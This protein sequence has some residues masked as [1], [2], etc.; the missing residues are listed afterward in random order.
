MPGEAFT[1]D[2]AALAAMLDGRLADRAGLAAVAPHVAAASQA[3]PFFVDALLESG[4]VRAVEEGVRVRVYALD[5]EELE[6]VLVALSPAGAPQLLLSEIPERAADFAELDYGDEAEARR[7]LTR[8][9]E[10]LVRVLNR[11]AEPARKLG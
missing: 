6:Y 7:A 11:L 9:A 8:A 5:D 10:R 3:L 1:L 4:S 2:E